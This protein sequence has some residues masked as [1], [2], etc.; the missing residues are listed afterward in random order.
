M[1]QHQEHAHGSHGTNL[2]DQSE[3][4]PHLDTCKAAITQFGEHESAQDEL[5]RKMFER[6]K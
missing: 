4:H 5:E 2:Q 6:A 3:N 1:N